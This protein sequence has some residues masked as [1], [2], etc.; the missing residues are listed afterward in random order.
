MSQ[1]KFLSVQKLSKTTRGGC[2]TSP[3][4]PPAGIRLRP[5]LTEGGFLS[6]ACGFHSTLGTLLHL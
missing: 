4:L 2:L 5:T 6:S 3:S 1:I